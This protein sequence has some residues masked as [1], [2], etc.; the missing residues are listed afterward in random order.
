MVS[1]KKKQV[2]ELKAWATALAEQSGRATKEVLDELVVKLKDLVK[3]PVLKSFEDEQKVEHALRMLKAMNTT[4][5]TKTGRDFEVHIID[6]TSPRRIVPKDKT[7][8]P[9][10]RADICGIALCIDEK[11]TSKEQD[12]KFFMLGLFDE[13][14]KLVDNLKRETTYTV[15]CSGEVKGGI[16]E[17]GHIEGVTN[18]KKSKEQMDID[19]EET[20]MKL[21]KL[22]TIAD[23][24]FNVTNPKVKGDMRLIRG[25][26]TYAGV[27]TA[28]SG[29][30]Y[31][32]YSI[33]DDSL[34]IE[35]IKKHGGLSVM[36]DKAQVLY[37][38][39]SSLY[40]LGSIEKSEQY[41]TGM[42]SN[43]ILPIIPIPRE[44][45]S[46][47]DIE[48]KDEDEPIDE[49]EELQL[50]E[51]TEEPEEDEPVEEPEEEPAEE[52]EEPE[53]EPDPPKKAPAKKKPEPPKKTS[54]KKEEEEDDDD[55]G[56]INLGED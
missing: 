33:I 30:V 11:S 5:L 10:D 22:I 19:V 48:E 49:D 23:A 55:G 24:E 21:F 26:V 42:S 9:Y 29:Y 50:G 2:S 3:L 56:S 40:F 44:Q 35:D 53:E 47:D 31:G 38:Q 32:R 43:C 13:N 18:F 15:K 8:E 20:L 34:D 12:V 7:K 46:V 37:D 4:P 45:E 14:T 1:M 25:D 16:W 28:E 6:K 41:G 27:H 17:L 52:P 36:V 51:D 54:K 39:G